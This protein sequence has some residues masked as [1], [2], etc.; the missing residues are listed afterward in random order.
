MTD[1]ASIAPA[2]LDAAATL[3]EMRHDADHPVRRA[4]PQLEPVPQTPKP[5]V[6]P[7]ESAPTP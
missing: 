2:T 3:D 7:L 6:Q 1:A 5:P 4:L